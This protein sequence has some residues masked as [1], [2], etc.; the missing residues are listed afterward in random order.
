MKKLIIYIVIIAGVI[1]Y[2][3]AENIK[4]TDASIR[5]INHTR[6]SLISVTYKHGSI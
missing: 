3:I 6:D 5:K 1:S 4:E 2:L